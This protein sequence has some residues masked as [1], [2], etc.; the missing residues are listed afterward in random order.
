MERKAL[1]IAREL[2]DRLSTAWALIFMSTAANIR[3][4]GFE[5]ENRV[6]NCEEGLA[7]F[8]ELD[9]KPGIAMGLNAL[10]VLTLGNGKYERAKDAFEA[11]LTVA[12]ETGERRREA[13]VYQNMESITIHQREYKGAEAYYR[14]AL[15]IFLEQG[16]NYG[17]ITALGQ[18]AWPLAA[19]G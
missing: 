5:Y 10:G 4:I 17:I 7:L 12:R 2:G 3:P 16:L 11:T 6:R 14:E 19:K 8:R 13:L 1:H 9:H 15:H 18:L